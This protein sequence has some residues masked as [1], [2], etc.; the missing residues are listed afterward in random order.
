[1]IAFV[2]GVALGSAF[3][4][5]LM[6]WLWAGERAGRAVATEAAPRRWRDG[7]VKKL[8]RARLEPGVMLH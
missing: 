3:G 6:G 1:M 8:T 7:G 2:C 5:C 4:V